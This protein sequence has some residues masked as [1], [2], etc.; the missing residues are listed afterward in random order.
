VTTDPTTGVKVIDPGRQDMPN[1]H[2]IL[3]SGAPTFIV[4][5]LFSQFELRTFLPL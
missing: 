4:A 5:P 1:G 3:L 2:S